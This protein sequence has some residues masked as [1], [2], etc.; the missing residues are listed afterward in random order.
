MKSFLVFIAS[1]LL[2]FSPLFAEAAKENNSDVVTIGISQLV[3]HPALDNIEKGIEDYLN[4]KGVDYKLDLQIANGEI[5]TAASIAQLFKSQGY[6]YVVGIATPTAQALA[7][8]ITDGTPVIYATVTDPAAAGL[9][10]LDYVCGTTDQAP[11]A[12]HLELIERVMNGNAKK[13]G[14]IYT[15]VE[16]NGMSQMETMRAECEK[17]GIELITQSVNNS[18]EVRAA[19]EAIIDRVDAVYVA[20]DN[21]VISAIASVAEVC[22]RNKTP[23][24][25]AD[26]TS[27]FGTDV[28]LSGG[29]DYYKAGLQTGRMLYDVINGKKP[30][31]LGMEYVDQQE[32]YINLDVAKAL[33]IE[34]DQELI[35]EAKYVIEN[36]VDIKQA[37]ENGNNE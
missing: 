30:S 35:D 19:T 1:I 28:L 37:S 2:M 20:I 25:T 32:I 10:G 18:S 17:N 13:I 23:L 21:T 22:M 9:E 29:F 36:G 4:E 12:K 33:S 27:A 34:I 7:N 26:T 24:F 3:S 31:E 5:S 8:T 11:I 14:M 15:S 6:D 16:A